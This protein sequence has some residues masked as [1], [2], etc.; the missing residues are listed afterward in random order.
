[1]LTSNK[2]TLNIKKKTCDK[3]GEYEV[4]EITH[5]RNP[6][7]KYKVVYMTCNKTFAMK[8]G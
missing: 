3:Y 4:Q 2:M 7:K 5:A 1:M 6:M 8:R